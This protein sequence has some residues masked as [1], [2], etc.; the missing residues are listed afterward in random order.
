MDGYMRVG[1]KEIKSLYGMTKEFSKY[2]TIEE[3][4]IIAMIY[5]NVAER[6]GDEEDEHL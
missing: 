4:E 6:I 5:S 1:I 2:L 3:Y